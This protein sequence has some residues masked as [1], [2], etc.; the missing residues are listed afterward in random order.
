[1]A[2]S[3]SNQTTYPPKKLFGTEGTNVTADVA[4]T[5]YKLAE[6]LNPL[7]IGSSRN[8]KMPKRA[9]CCREIYEDYTLQA[10][11]IAQSCIIS[12]KRFATVQI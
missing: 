1:M 10:Y 8:Y 4:V 12:L 5:G 6:N 3:I 11:I 7:K 9:E 2:G